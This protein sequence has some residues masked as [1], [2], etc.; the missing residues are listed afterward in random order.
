M[1]ARYKRPFAALWLLLL[2]T[3]ISVRSLACSGEVIAGVDLRTGKS[4]SVDPKKASLG[5]V[6]VFLSAKCPCSISH[7]PSLARLSGD[8]PGFQFVGVHSNA[9]EELVPS[10]FHFQQ[11]PIGFPVVRDRELRL[12]NAFGAFKTPH[13]FVV[14]P[15]GEC[16]F[17]GGVDNSRDAGRATGFYLKAA[18]ESVSRG[19][20][21]AV[22]LA[23]TLGCVIKR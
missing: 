7:E 12:A 6:V 1:Q 11:S 10:T 16:V 14:S 15:S 19:E 8:F 13:A 17:Q 4:V 21:P 3:A 20:V 5:T 2:M 18:L 23:R 22:K 9:E